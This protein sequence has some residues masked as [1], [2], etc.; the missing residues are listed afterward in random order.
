MAKK[1]ARKTTHKRKTARRKH[2]KSHARRSKRAR[3]RR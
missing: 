3:A 2:G 1:R